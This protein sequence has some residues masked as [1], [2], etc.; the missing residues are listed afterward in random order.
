MRL[1]RQP[2]HHVTEYFLW[3]ED[4]GH[5]CCVCLLEQCAPCV[6]VT[7]VQLT[8]EG[9]RSRIPLTPTSCTRAA[10]TTE[11]MLTEPGAIGASGDPSLRSRE[12]PHATV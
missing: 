3:C 7:H 6:E 10:S 4:V 5:P 1:G 11:P 2:E 9:A 12:T 8:H